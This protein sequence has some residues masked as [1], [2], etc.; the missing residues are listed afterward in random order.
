MFQKSLAQGRFTLLAVSLF[1][2]LAW[3]ALPPHVSWLLGGGLLACAV[4]VYLLT[5][6]NNTFVLLRRGS[7]MI[8]CVL[9][10][11]LAPAVMLHEL[12][13]A[14]IILLCSVVA[15]FPFFA[16]YQRP[17]ATTFVYLAFL[18]ISIS[19]VPFPQLL[20]FVPICWVA[21]V[22]LRAM[23]LRGLVASLM[24]IATPYCFL[25]TW[26]YCTDSMPL[27][28]SRFAE[29]MSIG[30]PD[31]TGWTLQHVVVASL[32]LLHFLVGSVDFLRNKHLDKTRTRYHYYT[33]LLNGGMAFAWLLLQP[34]YFLF[35]IPL[36]MTNASLLSGH[37]MALSYGKVQNVIVI[38][39]TLL[40]VA[41]CALA[42]FF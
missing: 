38:L 22:L 28:T 11:L 8:G 39:L 14:H 13:V 36:C 32:T 29:L 17:R 19:S 37:F 24:G 41:A 30:M 16:T 1:A 12:Q 33:S 31:F 7:S 9:A 5:E 25:L 35:I 21:L 27:L 26:A 4:C 42:A 23:S 15:Y 10:L 40:S 20:H 34:Q 18:V 2:V 3:V 6:L